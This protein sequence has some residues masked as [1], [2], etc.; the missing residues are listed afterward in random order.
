MQKSMW[1]GYTLHGKV[2]MH[3]SPY[4]I[5]VKA[6]L[7]PL[8]F[9]KAVDLLV[10][11]SDALRTI[12]GEE[13]GVPYQQVSTVFNYFKYE[14]LSADANPVALADQKINSDGAHIFD[15]SSC[16]FQVSL[17]KIDDQHFRWC[18][19]AHHLIVDAWSMKVAYEHLSAI[20]TSIETGDS[21]E[22]VLLPS[23]HNF[24][25]EN[26]LVNSAKSIK[27]ALP[28][29]QTI[30]GYPHNA[31]KT[32]RNIRQKIELSE[33]FYNYY[34]NIQ[35]LAE[36]RSFSQKLAEY[37]TLTTMITVWLSQLTESDHLAMDTPV[38]NRTTEIQ[39]QTIG[40]FISMQ[41]FKLA[42]T[43]TD[44]YA[45]I[46]K[47]VQAALFDTMKK[48]TTPAPT[49]T[50]IVYNY[51]DGS[52]GEFAD[53]P[54]EVAWHHPGFVD[55]VHDL[56]IQRL[57]FDE[58][59]D[60]ELHLDINEL[61]YSQSV[62]Q[63]AGSQLELIAKHM[64]ESPHALISEQEYVTADEMQV[65][66]T[67]GLPH[68]E[69]GDCFLA[70]FRAAC[71][72]H[73]ERVAVEYDDKSISYAKLQEMI[74]QYASVLTSKG[75][76]AGDPVGVH[77]ARSVDYVVATM[78][79]LS[80]GA[81]FVPLPYHM[82]VRRRDVIIRG[83]NLRYCIT[84][85][86]DVSGI[87]KLSLPSACDSQ[88][89]DRESTADDMSRTAYIMYTSGSTGLPKG[90]EISHG[91]LSNY[92]HAAIDKYGI[93]L[94][95]VSALYTSIGFDL[96]ITSLFPVLAA[97]GRVVVFADTSQRD[98]S[99]LEVAKDDRITFLKATP[100]HLDI[101][102]REQYAGQKIDT[103]VVGGEQLYYSLASQLF[104]V[105]PSLQAIINE[106]G[107]TELTVG[108]IVFEL[109]KHKKQKNAPVPIGTPLPGVEV[110]LLDGSHNRVVIGKLGQLY[111]SGEQL[112]IGYYNDEVR[113]D[114]KFSFIKKYGK[115]YY[116]TGDLARYNAAGNLIYEGRVDRQ[117]KVRGKRVEIGEI[118]GAIADTLGGI[119][120]V[121]A[122][123]FDPNDNETR[124]HCLKCGLPDTYPNIEIEDGICELCSTFPE[125]EKQASSYFEDLPSLQKKLSTG[126][127]NPER[128]YDC[129]A[130]LSGGKDSTYMVSQ[131]VDLGFHVL[132]FTLDN[133]YISKEAILNIQKVVKKLKVDHVFGSTPVM[134]DVFVDSLNRHANVCN[135]CFK[136]IYTLSIQIALKHKIP[137][138]VTGLSRGQFFETRLTEELF[139]KGNT[140]EQIDELV[141]DARKSYHQID[142][143]VKQKMDVSFLED[144]DTFEKV[145]FIDF[146]RYTDISLE[147][148]YD[149]LGTK[150]PW[151]RPSD[152]GRST[153]CLINQAGI[154]V[155]KKKK[156]YS[157]YAYP[158]SWDV[159]LGHKTIKESLEEIN[160][161]IDE[162]TVDKILDEI[163]YPR[164]TEEQIIAYHTAKDI[165]VE[166]LKQELKLALDED[167]VPSKF[168]YVEDMPLTANGKVDESLLPAANV[169]RDTKT[170]YE[171]PQDDLEQ[172]LYD[173]FKDVLNIQIFSVHDSF[174]NLGGTSLHAIR[175]ATRV[176]SELNL[177]IKLHNVFE[178]SSVRMLSKHL[179]QLMSEILA[180][181]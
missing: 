116:E 127:T 14:D 22:A 68:D 51:I 157:N 80:I 146:Y 156:G 21:P 88:G 66:D 49:S 91:S 125:Y 28:K 16:C 115:R 95:T 107:P 97:G 50:N 45:T 46:Y 57:A 179:E 98:L 81:P 110:L 63:H 141:L 67:A 89:L 103:I 7:D 104:D 129:L 71:Q 176:E 99:V 158:Y 92:V 170:Y 161:Y 159:R 93:G 165:D 44:S 19:N 38:A 27:T 172:F 25:D 132:A 131:L 122:N 140:P 106:Y 147:G 123:N 23:Y 96:T 75:I 155:H 137:F 112:A 72:Q 53:R 105:L 31:I 119:V 83:A 151:I 94:D 69:N 113:T 143:V 47:K 149:Y 120:H 54:T 60:F 48:G 76:A 168:I 74:D 62:L 130:L 153:N 164:S 126:L 101:L 20:Y 42:V 111:I 117:L 162:A 13:E 43:E 59:K 24:L 8:V 15:I 175:I 135:G 35:T 34:K 11:R 174:I 138:I 124:H 139:L 17:Y 109:K 152:T 56:R 9:E 33:N 61:L 121:T 160:E 100:S 128:A 150:V 78:A 163:N 39:K 70:L 32:Q 136:V 37:C 178:Y 79:L 65:M 90:V 166:K 6:K 52:F 41:P 84:D 2:P 169:D 1:V 167:F 10:H 30:L 40:C 18:F 102:V 108:C 26:R 134:N 145:K 118:Q 3:N 133:G 114:A 4:I 144:E 12:F 177:S 55:E 148:I 36:Y 142:D 29:H 64:M 73:G 154:Y 58:T 173:I 82:P 85:R 87:L 171:E 86:T 5:T 180:N 77:T 181:D